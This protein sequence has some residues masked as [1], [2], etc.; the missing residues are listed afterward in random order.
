MMDFYRIVGPECGRDRKGEFKCVCGHC[1]KLPEGSTRDELAGG[2]GQDGRKA[3]DLT[4][5]AE[6]L[7]ERIKNLE[8]YS[9]FTRHQADKSSL[10]Q[11]IFSLAVALYLILDV[12]GK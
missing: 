9:V 7:E 12:L 8:R 11:A 3:N 10:F 6:E 5:R 4:G 2:P 1:E